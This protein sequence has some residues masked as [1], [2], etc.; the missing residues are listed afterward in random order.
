[1]KMQYL[2]NEDHEKEKERDE[3]REEKRAV[4]ALE[5]REGYYI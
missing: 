2:G 5:V 4:R 1:M 3:K